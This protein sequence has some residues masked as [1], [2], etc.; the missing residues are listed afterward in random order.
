MNNSVIIVTP[1]DDT[2]LDGIRIVLVD[3]SPEQ[4]QIVSDSLKEIDNK[5]RVILYYWKMGNPVDWLLTMKPKANLIIFNADASANGAI[6]LIIGYMAAQ[7]N[8]Y[9]FG[10]L[11][12]LNKVNDSIIYAKEDLKKLFLNTLENYE[13]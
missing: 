5:N 1:P 4:T 2:L 10:T 11:R 6:E 12:D 3:L 7:S 13:T 8:S 9:Y